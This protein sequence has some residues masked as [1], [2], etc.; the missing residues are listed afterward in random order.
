MGVGLGG[1]GVVP[2]GLV[3]SLVGSFVGGWVGFWVDGFVDGGVVV[4]NAMANMLAVTIDILLRPIFLWY[5]GLRLTEWTD[6]PFNP[7]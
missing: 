4:A 6:C 3:V 7:N 2:G 5:L 1:D